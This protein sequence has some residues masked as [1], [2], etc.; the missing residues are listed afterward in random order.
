VTEPSDVAQ[1]LAEPRG[2]HVLGRTFAYFCVDETFFGF[3]MW[4]TP[5]VE[6]ATLLCRVMECELRPGIPRHHSLVHFGNVERVDAAAFDVLKQYVETHATALAD[7]VAGQSVVFG[8][9]GISSMVVAGY[10]AV[11][12][13]PYPARA[14]GSTRDAIAWMF[15]AR[16]ELAE[17]V[18]ALRELARGVAPVVAQLRALIETD[19]RT[20][21][22]AAAA[23]KLG[24]TARTLQRRL[25]DAQTTFQREHA[26]VQLAKAKQLL[27]ETET[28]VAVIGLEVGFA[29]ASH[30][31]QQFRKRTG[32][33]PHAWRGRR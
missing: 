7:R 4:G 13:P 20:T 6:D 32:M 25:R 31:S 29:S 17:P 2:R 10:L 21:S 9:G 16:P 1:M 3:V 26:H 30:F 8:R 18:E 23:A 27:T 12:P 19:L 14:F 24:C 15:P 33:S 28:K 5:T 22:I 11:F